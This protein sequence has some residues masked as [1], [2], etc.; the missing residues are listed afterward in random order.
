M[1]QRVHAYNSPGC[2]SL[3]PASFIQEKGGIFLQEMMPH[4][5][6]G[7]TAQSS[8]VFSLCHPMPDNNQSNNQSILGIPSS[9]QTSLGLSTF[10]LSQNLGLLEMDQ[11]GEGSQSKTQNH[12][13]THLRSL[14]PLPVPEA[15]LGVPEAAVGWLS[16]EPRKTA[17]CICCGRGARPMSSPRLLSLVHVNGLSRRDKDFII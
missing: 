2:P 10:T 17:C 1:T 7:C 4:K 12:L 14:H 16:G 8:S 9:F 13:F 11:S 15:A 5:R 3:V 6:A